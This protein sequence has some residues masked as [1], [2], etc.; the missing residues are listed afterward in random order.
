MVISRSDPVAAIGSLRRRYA[1]LLMLRWLPIGLISPVLVLVILDRG[2]T[3]GQLGPVLGAY[4]L[5][6]L[7]AELPTGGLADAYGRRRTLVTSSV[8]MA[9]FLVVLLIADGLV[10]ITLGA[11]LGGAS[12][13]LD[14]GPLEAWFVDAARAVDD[15]LASDAVDSDGVNSGV[16]DIER[17]LARGSA[18]DGVTLAVG[19]LAGGFLGSASGGDLGVVVTAALVAQVAHAFFAF[20]LMTN[21]VNHGAESPS[22]NQILRSAVAVIVPSVVLRLLL[23]AGMAV[24]VALISIENLFQ[25]RFNDLLDGR[26]STTAVLGVLLAASFAASAFGA[27]VGPVIREQLGWQVGRFLF[28]IVLLQGACFVVMALADSVVPTAA[29][30]VGL[31]ALLGMAH[32]VARALLHQQV[33]ARERTT[34][35]SAQSLS[36]QLGAFLGAVSLVPLASIWSVPTVWLVA[37]AVMLSAAVLYLGI[38]GDRS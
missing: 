2:I 6:T 19:A 38:D 23:V 12:R 1:A 36:M 8:L 13:A 28:V 4:S 18:V 20:V 5:V 14:S 29:A 7:L 30:M 10:P 25:V 11:M 31:Y 9:G 32:P 16:V 37:G 34:M 3:V 15:T 22:P 26:D 21:S 35:I 17:E 24:G 27:A 33:E